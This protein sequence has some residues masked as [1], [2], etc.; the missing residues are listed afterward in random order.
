MIDWDI[1]QKATDYK[2]FFIFLVIVLIIILLLFWPVLNKETVH[3]RW[4]P[5]LYDCKFDE[6]HFKSTGNFRKR[7]S[8]GYGVIDN[9]SVVICGLGYN[10]GEKKS[11]KLIEKLKCM[12][13]CETKKYPFKMDPTMRFSW[14]DARF[15]IYAADSTDDTYKILKNLTSDDSRFYFPD[16]KID[17]TG[18]NVFEKMSKLRNYLIE[19]A[20][21]LVEEDKSFNPDYLIMT[22]LDLVGPTSCDGIAHSV[23]LIEDGLYR[24]VFSNGLV[25][26]IFSIHFP[27]IGYT[28]YDP[29]ATIRPHELIYPRS[30]PE[31]NSIIN[32]PEML[33]TIKEETIIKRDFLPSNLTLIR[34][35]G[36]PLINAVSGFAGFAIY[37]FEL[38][39]PPLLH[40]SGPNNVPNKKGYRYILNPNLCEHLTLH[41]QMYYDYIPMCINPSLLLLSG[42]Q[43]EHNKSL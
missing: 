38:F 20:G 19:Y 6:L 37:D 26:G 15:V 17:K 18:L 8:K 39:F 12:A 16:D 23:S 21:K 25:S 14:K 40:S 35:K 3:Q 34:T 10:L 4:N 9:S 24:A 7:M 30:N 29:L 5:D 41:L 22:D 33:R 36:D 27:V 28:Y 43:G 2:W 32:D 13:D 31:I 1:K 42:I 11:R